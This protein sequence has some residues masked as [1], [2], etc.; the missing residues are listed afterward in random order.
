MNHPRR[1]AMAANLASGFTTTG[2]PAA[3]SMGRSL[4][5]SA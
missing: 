2:K 1:R 5:E 4:V 3:S